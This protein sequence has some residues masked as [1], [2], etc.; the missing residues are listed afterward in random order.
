MSSTAYRSLTTSVSSAVLVATLAWPTHA[1]NVSVEQ[2]SPA[3]SSETVLEPIVITGRKRTEREVDAPVS[4]V[5]LKGDRLTQESLDPGAAILRQTPNANFVDLSRPGD[6]YGTMRGIGPLGSP[7]NS[8]DSTVGFAIDGV[9]TSAFGFSQPLVDVDQV[10]VLRGPQGTLFGRNTLGGLVNVVGRGADGEREFRLTGEVGT[11]GHRLI[12]GTAAGWLLPDVLAG[13][14]ALRFQGFDGDIP[15]GI[16]GGKDGE[17]AIA[18]GRGT[19][20]LTPDDSWQI[21]LTGSFSRD[22]R[23]NPVWLLK[24][25]PGFPLSGSDIEPIGNRDIYQGTLSIRKEFEAFALTSITSYQHL[26]LDSYDEFAD[27]YIYSRWLG[28]TPDAW[29]DPSSEKGRVRDREGLFNQEIRLN[30]LEDSPVTWVAGVNYFRSDYNTFRVMQSSLWPTAN[31]TTDNDIL[32]ETLA[33]FGDVS[34]PLDDRWEV[35]GGLRLAHD[36]QT[37]DGRY[38]SNGFAGTVPSLTQRN[39]VSD[40]YVTGRAA[41]SYRWT[42]D[43][44]TYASIARGYSSGGFERTTQNAPYGS[45]ADPFLPATGWTYEIGTKGLATDRLSLNA[46]LFYNDIKNG[47]LSAF[48]MTTYQVFF[49]NQDYRSYGLELGGAYELTDEVVLTGGVGFTKSELANVSALAG[50]GIKDGNS[51]PQ[52]P[53]WTSNLGIE[54]RKDMADWNLDGTLSASVNHQYVGSRQTDVQNNIKLAPY[55]ILNAKIGWENEDFGIYA[56]ANNILDERPISYASAYGP[57]V[58]AVIVGRGRVLGLGASLKW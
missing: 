5:I 20:R 44:M 4:T 41:V 14:G 50:A 54:Y 49:T 31:G 10:E 37:L 18:A 53:E 21:D 29:A 35:S 19:L 47:Q 2:A 46:S 42:P 58:T 23:S 34:V 39:A 13:R 38:V 16:I 33:V 24:E 11:D 22:H 45:P 15:N 6:R 1:Q 48:D 9:P 3:A 57:G 56:F 12:E 26:D 17:A 30:S 43:W 32:S 7:L 25:Q 8:L 27:S 40:T 28:G 55:H 51:V 52:S 36:R